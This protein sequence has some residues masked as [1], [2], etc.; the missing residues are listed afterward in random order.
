MPPGGGRSP[1]RGER[2]RRAAVLRGVH[3][4]GRRVADVLLAHAAREVLL[5]LAPAPRGDGEELVR[6]HRERGERR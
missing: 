5:R 6:A 3:R 1:R 4:H 2:D